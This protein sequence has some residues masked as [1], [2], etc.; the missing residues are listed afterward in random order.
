MHL[1]SASY[2]LG[3]EDTTL[4]TP[5][6]TTAGSIRHCPR[7]QVSLLTHPS[8]YKKIVYLF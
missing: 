4:P 8:H 7:I 1:A 5:P 2:F 3:L 6:Y